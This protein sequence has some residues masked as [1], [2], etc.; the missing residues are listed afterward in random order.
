MSSPADRIDLNVGGRIFSTTRSTLLLHPESMLA[1]LV[2]FH[3]NTEATTTAHQSIP[4]IFIDR[5]P[6]VFQ[7]VLSYLRTDKVTFT[8][9]A[10]LTAAAVAADAEYYGL[11]GL[12]EKLREP[13]REAW[14]VYHQCGAY[15]FQGPIEIYPSICLG[16]GALGPGLTGLSKHH[17]EL[18]LSLLQQ[19]NTEETRVGSGSRWIVTGAAIGAAIGAAVR[20]A[21]NACEAIV[22]L[23]RVGQ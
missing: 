16:L 1:G 21:P 20:N 19:K 5:D 11:H 13:R 15:A 3:T 12:L 7:V 9:T 23:E 18:L 6:D 17:W 8:P 4:T 22:I 14:Q 10:T 2:R